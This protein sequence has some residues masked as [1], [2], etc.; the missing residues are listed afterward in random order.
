[1]WWHHTQGLIPLSGLGRCSRVDSIVH[2]GLVKAP[3]EHGVRGVAFIQ[4]LMPWDHGEL[5]H[6]GV[7]L[8]MLTRRQQRWPV[9]VDFHW[10]HRQLGLQW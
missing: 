10:G 9:G 4:C 7:E 1:M 5:W 3:G 8:V 6:G 2:L